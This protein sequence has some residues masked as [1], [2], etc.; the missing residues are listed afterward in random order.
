MSKK[1]T[2]HKVRTWAQL[3]DRLGRQPISKTRESCIIMKDKHGNIIPLKLVYD[4]NGVNWWLEEAVLDAPIADVVEEVHGRW[5][6]QLAIEHSIQGIHSCHTEYRCSI[7]NEV[8]LK[9]SN[10]CPN[11]DAKMDLEE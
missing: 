11:C 7:C 1:R 9:K 2:R 10:H 6:P 8:E 5:I 3:Y 4:E